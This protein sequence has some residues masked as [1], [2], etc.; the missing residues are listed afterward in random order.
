[1]DFFALDLVAHADGNVVEHVKHV[2]LGHHP[3]VHAVDDLRVTQEWQVNPAAAAWTTGD[4]AIFVAAGA[5][6]VCNLAFDLAGEGATAY[7]GAVSLGHTDHGLNR[8]GS[9]AGAG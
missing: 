5:K 7:A 8:V 6:L 3:P 4:R 9:N 1:I 2:E